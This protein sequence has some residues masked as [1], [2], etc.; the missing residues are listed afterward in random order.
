M[1]DLMG[2]HVGQPVYKLF[3]QLLRRWVPV[4]SWFV[5]TAPE[6]MAEAVSRFAA[7]GHTVRALSG[8]L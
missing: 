4:S 6:R 1:Y 3:G 8:R 5:A 2:K 7:M